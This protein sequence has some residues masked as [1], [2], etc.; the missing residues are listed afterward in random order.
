MDSLY[1]LKDLLCDEI[2][3]IVEKNDITPTELERAYK[4]VDI[5]KDIVTIDAME[6]S[7]Y[8]YDDG[9]SYARGGSQGGYSSRRDSMGRYSRNSGRY[10]RNRGYSRADEKEAM[11]DKI[12]EMQ[13]KVE[14]M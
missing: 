11:L 4:A 8:S 13:R 2:G 5:I 7:D 9:M 12:E 10:S 3:D 6:N 14:Q 1:A